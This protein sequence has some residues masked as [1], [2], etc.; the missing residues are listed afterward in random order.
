MTQ[1]A[2]ATT[3]YAG[4]RCGYCNR[5]L[6]AAGKIK[7]RTYYECPRCAPELNMVASPGDYH[8]F[9]RMARKDRVTT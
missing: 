3:M 6:V 4:T 9:C 8:Y 2:F 5:P 7:G 1:L